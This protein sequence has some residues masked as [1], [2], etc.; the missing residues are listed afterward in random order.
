MTDNRLKLYFDLKHYLGLVSL[1]LICQIVQPA[2]MLKTS[3]RIKD[4]GL[5]L[6]IM[7]LV[8]NHQSNDAQIEIAATEDHSN[9][10]IK[11]TD[12]MQALALEFDET[13]THFI[14]N[15]AIGQAKLNK[16]DCRIINDYWV[17]DINLL[18]QQLAM[19]ITV[20]QSTFAI[21]IDSVWYQNQSI[22][23]DQVV[24]PSGAV[25]NADFSSSDNSLS[26]IRNE[27]FFRHQNDQTTQFSETDLGGR[28][29]GGS[30][31]LTARDYLEND[32]YIEDYL[33]LNTTTNSRYM[34]GNQVLSLNPL[35]ESTDFTGLQM[36]WS[37]QGIQP[38][39]KNIHSKQLI[40]DAYGSIRSFNG[41]GIPGGRVELRIEG[42]KLAQTISRLDGSFEFNDIEIPA[43]QYV[44]I[45]AW[46][47]RPN[48]TGVPSE[49]IDLSRYNNNRN[50]ANNT[51]LFQGGLGLNGNAI[52][53]PSSQLDE[54]AY[55][56]SQYTFNDHLTINGLVQTID[57]RDMALLGTRGYW[58]A[59]GYWE[60]DT[61]VMDSEQAWRVETNN[62][63][64][65][66]LFRAGAQHRPANWINDNQHPYDDRFAELSSTHFRSFNLSVIHRRTE[67]NG[68]GINYTLPALRWRPHA[69]LSLQA[70]PDYNGDYIYRGHWKINSN[71]Q[72]NIHSNTREDAVN[73]QYNFKH[74]ST[75]NLLHI[76]RTD[77]AYKTSLIYNQSNQGLRSPGW[78]VGLIAGQHD[79]GYLAQIEY[80][81]IPGLRARAQVIRDPLFTT[82]N[83]TPD[84]IY[85][86]SVVAS[87]NVG[88]GGLTRGHYYRLL[89]NSGSI[90]GRVMFGDQANKQDFADLWVL[91]NN[92]RRVQTEANGQF[93]IRNLDPGIYQV[94]LDI[95]GLPF[96][97]T[98]VKE[99]YWVEVAASSNS[100]FEYNMQLKLGLSGQLFETDGMALMDSTF[101]VHNETGQIITQG[102]TNRF[103]QFRL[104]NLTPGH[105]W[106][107]SSSNHCATLQL[108][109]RYL[110][111]QKY[112][113]VQ[114]QTCEVFPHE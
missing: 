9:H 104:E 5:N 73:W 8:I 100:Y 107:K 110:T 113:L 78:S 32:P 1:L 3:N 43:G 22:N 19:E 108:T 103:G 47:Y 28:L 7:P 67:N 41:V 94:K 61:A 90:S 63:S 86:L 101:T 21:Y 50:L 42:V 20:D 97:L 68:Q 70:R 76:N 84:T 53:D 36:A 6:F 37:N 27:Y 34:L 109:D 33:W 96:E 81:L 112:R 49:V 114:N 82:T 65:N 48:Q 88:K 44:E 26:F 55:L 2:M 56:R 25:T 64:A 39:L 99:S 52:E 66:W 69:R 14:I 60:I 10:Y 72:L 106:L 92:Q 51:W 30:W 35:L 71:Q 13:D 29:F 46:V 83:G 75:L 93:S 111:M 24:K 79:W 85:G 45:E 102:S 17:M 87:F 95:A 89:N 91:I 74:S 4:K 15:T 38:F 105:Y 11:I 98:P 18:G 77:D 12:F 58:G 59:A 80:E 31:Q 62:Q 57:N 16:Q 54:A 23:R 40:N